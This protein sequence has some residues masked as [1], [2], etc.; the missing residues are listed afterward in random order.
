MK[1]QKGGEP[2]VNRSIASKDVIRSSQEDEV[3]WSADISRSLELLRD[4]QEN[5]KATPY[6]IASLDIIAPG[7][8]ST[9]LRQQ[10]VEFFV[11]EIIANTDLLLQ[12]QPASQKVEFSFVWVLL[13]KVSNLTLIDPSAISKI[14]HLDTIR[15][16]FS[17]VQNL[18]NVLMG[19]GATVVAQYMLCE[20]D[21]LKLTEGDWEKEAAQRKLFSHVPKENYFQLRDLAMAKF[22]SP[23]H[24]AQ[25]HLPA[26]D[27]ERVL[28]VSTDDR[29]V[30]VNAVDF[31][32][33]LFYSLILEAE[34][35]RVTA[36][37]G[38]AVRLPAKKGFA[39]AEPLPERRA[40]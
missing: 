38:L 30:K 22:T 12:V 37:D 10:V 14:P 4:W 6:L 5:T 35:V 18:G 8:V 21:G 40:V 17:R 9:Q 11:N 33:Q 7:A 23:D 3:D 36:E 20:P 26:R 29:K 24:F 34:E 19:S 1:L 25:L 39:Q 16:Q 2:R 28:Q 27:I 15:Q 13:E 31:S 32:S